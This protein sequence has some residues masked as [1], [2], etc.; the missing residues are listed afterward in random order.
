MQPPSFVLGPWSL[1]LG[2]WSLVQIPGSDQG[3]RTEGPGLALHRFEKRGSMRAVFARHPK[4]AT[5]KESVVVIRRVG[6]LS[7]AKVAGLAYVI[8]G[9]I[10]GACVSLFMVPILAVAA[11]FIL[12][13]ITRRGSE[14]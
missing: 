8:L 6:A 13:D 11:T 4:L 12:R 2:P 3:R 5:A 1:V 9:L 7:C 10:I 14:V